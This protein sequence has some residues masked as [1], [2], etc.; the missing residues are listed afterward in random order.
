VALYKRKKPWLIVIVLLLFLNTGAIVAILFFQ[1]PLLNQK[2]ELVKE[3]RQ[4]LAALE[5]G[6]ANS[7]YR[8]GKNDLE[9]L[10]TMIPAKR[11][12]APLLAEIMADAAACRVSSDALTYKP[13]H[14]GQKNL[15]VYHISLSVSG[16]Y[17]DIRCYLYKMQARKDL[18]VIDAV[19][20][21]NDDPY[22]EKVSMDLK[23]TTYLRDG[24]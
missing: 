17:A 9:K 21:K 11:Q 6:D 16:R 18:V 24:A 14:L 15:L 4:G 20:L 23:L 5:R 8:D 12:F 13:E 3:H 7:V 2:R 19:T 10:R 22:V 1:G